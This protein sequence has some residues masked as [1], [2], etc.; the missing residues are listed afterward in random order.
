MVRHAGESEQAEGAERQRH[1]QR[2]ARPALEMRQSQF[3]GLDGLTFGRQRQYLDMALLALA[4]VARDQ[5]AR[6]GRLFARQLHFGVDQMGP[7]A[8]RM[9]QCEITV[10]FDRR[11]QCLRDAGPR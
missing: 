5:L 11:V 1:D 9:G 4:A 3:Q 10:C 8:S 7:R 2:I 6:R